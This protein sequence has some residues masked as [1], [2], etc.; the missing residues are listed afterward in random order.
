MEIADELHQP[1]VDALYR[2]IGNGS[3]TAANVLNHLYASQVNEI[4]DEVPVK[5]ETSSATT[6]ADKTFNSGISVSGVE[7]ENEVWIKLAKCCTPVPG[8]EIIGF[9]TKGQG[10]SVHRA[11]CYNV[12]VLRET[13]EPGRFIEV[14]WR[15]DAT[16]S[17]LVQ[18]QVEGLDRSRLLADVT[19]VLSENHVNIISG[20]VDTRKDR[21]ALSKWTFEM[22]DLQHLAIVMSAIRKIDGVFDVYRVV[23]KKA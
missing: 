14:S 1:S 15:P 5:S 7:D 13:T 16:S 10:I 2:A 6:S 17:F 19:K 18:I 22:G 4:A 11:D 9:V 8:D 23:G 21:V 3:L 12:S 20:Q